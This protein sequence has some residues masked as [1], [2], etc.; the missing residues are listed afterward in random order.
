MVALNRAQCDLSRIET[1]PG[2]VQE[3]KPDLIVNAAAYTAVD[4][5]E[6]EEALATTINGTAV[7]VLA[8]QA[9]KR[10]ALMVHYS[11]DYVFDGTKP[12]PYTEEDEPNPINA[13]GRSKLAG[14]Q[15]VAE[16]GGEYLI[17]RTTWVYAARGHNFI[18]T[19]L[20]LAGER[21]EL[22]IIDD[23][24][25][26]PT[27]ARNIADATALALARW[28]LLKEQGRELPSGIFNLTAAGSA[29]WF[30]AGQ[31]DPPGERSLWTTACDWTAKPPP[32]SYHGLSFAG[33]PA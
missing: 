12:T 21:D 2:I 11:T 31:R 3:I 17:F 22:K 32:H 25:G 33:A 15:A 5:A 16:V 1:I 28:M 26:A 18:K 14:E 13:Y 30:W 7:G 27:W 10:N 4:K 8:E 19:I 9:R 23:Q 29:S 20:R 24:H 6:A